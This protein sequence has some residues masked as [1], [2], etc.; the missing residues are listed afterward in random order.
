MVCLHIHDR[1]QFWPAERTSAMDRHPLLSVSQSSKRRW[2]FEPSTAIKNCRRS[3]LVLDR[4]AECNWNLLIHVSLTIQ[5]QACWCDI[6]HNAFAVQYM[7][8][9]IRK[10]I[11]YVRQVLYILDIGC[12]VLKAGLQQRPVCWLWPW[13]WQWATEST[14]LFLSIVKRRLWNWWWT[15]GQFVSGVAI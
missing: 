8:H 7:Q 13:R 3:D 6:S 11:I 10:R 2:Y 14:S 4:M 9:S 15:T 5:A 12:F 1:W